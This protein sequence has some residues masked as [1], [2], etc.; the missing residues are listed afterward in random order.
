MLLVAPDGRCWRYDK[1]YPWAWERAY[2]RPRKDPIQ[3]ADTDLGRI[4][5]LICWD[6]G[7]APLW[8][9]YAGQIDLLIFS[10]CP[11]LVHQMDVHLPDG[12]VIN[13]R[14]L[15]R[16]LQSAYRGAEHIF[17]DF[18]LQQARWLS[19]PSANTTGA[20]SFRSH[21]PRPKFAALSF[22]AARPV[23]WRYIAQADEIEVSAGYFNDTFVADASGKQLA[24]T[25]TEGDDLAIAAVLLADERPKPQGPQPHLGL[26]PL[27]Y[28]VDWYV[29][30]ALKRYY[31]QRWRQA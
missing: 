17:G 21:L 9:Q 30:A 5:M 6:V 16:L 12:K 11:P 2:F 19:V 22:F 4:G 1:S 27:T 26:G 23:L 14:Q 31:N 8:A 3:V 15:G 10:S 25:Q 29:N 7:H 24:R 20:G 28:F 18:Y 13:S